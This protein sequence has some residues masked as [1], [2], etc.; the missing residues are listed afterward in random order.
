MNTMETINAL[1]TE[2][3]KELELEPNMID[4]LRLETE[5]KALELVKELLED[6][7]HDE[8]DAVPETVSV[9]QILMKQAET[10]AL[11][12]LHTINEFGPSKV[13]AVKAYRAIAGTDLRETLILVNALQTKHGL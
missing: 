9:A 4:M 8:S 12:W 3:Q 6:T 5:V 13:R 11:E 1:I 2:K 10:A 7:G